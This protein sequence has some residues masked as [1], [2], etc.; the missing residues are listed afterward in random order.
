M[1]EAQVAFQGLRKALTE[2][3]VLQAVQTGCLFV[4]FTDASVKGTGAV[5]SQ[6]TSE[7]EKP[8]QY[9]NRQLMPAEQNYA[10]IEKEAL[11]VKWAID[12]LWYYLW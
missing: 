3:H 5:L 1:L 6:V 4:L 7:G 9:L 8:M 10:T 11:A 12:T 2:E